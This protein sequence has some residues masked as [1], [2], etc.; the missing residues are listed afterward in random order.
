MLLEARTRVSSDREAP[1][2]LQSTLTKK[3]REDF[4]EKRPL[5][6]SLVR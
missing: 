4:Q 1:S 5:K 2:R 6:Q 3:T